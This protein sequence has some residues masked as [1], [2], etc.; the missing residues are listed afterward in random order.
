MAGYL[1]TRLSDDWTDRDT[2]KVGAAGF[3]VTWVCYA[4]VNLFGVGLHSYGF[5]K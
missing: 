3:V 4:G 2:N 5:F 1:H